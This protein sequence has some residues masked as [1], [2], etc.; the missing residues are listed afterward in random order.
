MWTPFCPKKANFHHES[1]CQ[2]NAACPYCGGANPNPPSDEEVIVIPD[3][4]PARVASRPGLSLN[5]V[6]ANVSRQKAM[7][8]VKE[9]R[10][11][12]PHAGLPAHGT[13]PKAAV[14]LGNLKGNRLLAS[15]NTCKVVISVNVGILQDEVLQIYGNWTN[16]SK[17]IL[18][19]YYLLNNTRS[20]RR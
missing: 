11:E 13:R 5:P 1:N 2:E 8:E 16:I 12:R 17:N 9:E 14:A 7:Q 10:R 6:P 19:Q 15:G 20:V 18:L 4:P 3:S